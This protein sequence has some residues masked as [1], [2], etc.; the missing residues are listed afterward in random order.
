MDA[1][2]LFLTVQKMLIFSFCISIQFDRRYMQSSSFPLRFS[3]SKRVKAK[4]SFTTRQF[5]FCMR[6]S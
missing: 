5:L 1:T 2:F 4:N 6:E 3:L